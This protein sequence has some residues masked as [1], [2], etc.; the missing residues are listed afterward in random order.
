MG[1]IWS[2]TYEAIFFLKN[3]PLITSREGERE[4]VREREGEGGRE[5][6]REGGRKGGKEGGRERDRE[7]GRA[8]ERK[9]RPV[10]TMRWSR[11]RM[12]CVSG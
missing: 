3:G 11:S 1:G 9:A 12:R 8:R 4:E 5:E 7:G 2:V 6:G 10:K